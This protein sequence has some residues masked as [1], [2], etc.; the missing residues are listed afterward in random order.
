M[1]IQA[2]W[3]KHVRRR[4]AAA[5]RIQ[6]VWRGHAE[7]CCSRFV[8]LREA[9]R[10]G[11]VW[12]ATRVQAAWRGYFVRH[13]HAVPNHFGAY[14]NLADSPQQ[15][16]ASV[17]AKMAQLY[18]GLD[19]AAREELVRM[20]LRGQLKQRRT[21]LAIAA[22]RC[23]RDGCTKFCRVEVVRERMRGPAAGTSYG[24]LGFPGV[25]R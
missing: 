2:A 13:E 6:T 18:P 8:S 4:A 16:A 9:G 23:Y 14:E 15:S 17:A 21:D 20:D 12:R 11:A 22:H 10:R 1:R 24:A 25:P 7:R 19:S 5:T 3:R